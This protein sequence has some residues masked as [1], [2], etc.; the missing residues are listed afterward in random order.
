MKRLLISRTHH[1]GFGS[2]AAVDKSNVGSPENAEESWKIPGPKDTVHDF[3]GA[4]IAHDNSMMRR[5]KLR[6]MLRLMERWGQ[7]GCEILVE[8]R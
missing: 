1:S 4:A 3:L 2:P 7:H 8:D 5:E 6:D